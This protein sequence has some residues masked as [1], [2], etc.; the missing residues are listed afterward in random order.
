MDDPIADA[1]RSIS[2]G[3]IVLDRKIAQ[4]A[5]FPA[6]DILQSTSRVMRNVVSP[7]HVQVAQFL[8]ENLSIYRDAEDLINIGAYKTGNNPKIDRAV[9][10]IDRINQFLRQD[11][12]EA[13][14][15]QQTQNA[16]AGLLGRG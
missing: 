8:R 9:Q 15:F 4:R 1:V 6:I 7:E 16:M 10:M 2:D 13:S 12:N 11:V 5:H 3:H 14:S